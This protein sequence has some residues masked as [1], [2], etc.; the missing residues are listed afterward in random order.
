[1]GC[2][3]ALL[4]P[5]FLSE[6]LR[7][8]DLSRTELNSISPHLTDW[9]GQV[10][11]VLGGYV[12]ATGMLVVA[13]AVTSF[14]ARPRIAVVGALIGGL[15]SIGVMTTVNFIINSEF[16]WMLCV[17]ACPWASSLGCYGIENLRRRR[18]KST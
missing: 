1:M 18:A 10:F 7:Y 12:A 11:H 8:I 4:R 15:A 5:A 16:K 9:L 3:F 17:I 2:Y 6:D 14:R 13:L